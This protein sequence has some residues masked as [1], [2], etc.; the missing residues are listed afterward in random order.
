[1]HPDYWYQSTGWGWGWSLARDRFSG[2]IGGATGAT[3]TSTES[4][5]GRFYVKEVS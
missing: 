3:A 5:A 1:M 2:Q 4:Q